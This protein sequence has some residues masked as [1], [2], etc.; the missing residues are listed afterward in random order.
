M[1]IVRSWNYCGYGNSL[2]E[3]IKDYEDYHEREVSDE[4]CSF[5][6]VKEIKVQRKFEVIKED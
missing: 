2:E 3:A 5:Y 1:F 4:E 6:E